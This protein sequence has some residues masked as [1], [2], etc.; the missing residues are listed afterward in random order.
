MT[1]IPARLVGVAGVA[2]AAS[3]SLAACGQIDPSAAAVVGSSSI[4]QSQLASMVTRGLADAQAAAQ[5]GSDKAQFT[6]EQLTRLI[7]ERI[8]DEAAAEHGVSVSEGDVDRQ[9]QTYAQQAGGQAQLEAQ[10]AQ[11]GVPPKDLRAFIRMLVLRNALGDRLIADLPVD[12]AKLEQAY[13]QASDQYDQ[14]HIAHILVS[15]K[16]TADRILAQAKADPGS[17]AALA[18]Q[19]SLDTQTKD[20]GGDL[21]FAGRTTMEQTSK[22]LADAVFGA[23]PGSFIEV[24]TQFGWHVVHV[25]E[26][27]TTSLAEA[28]PEL[29]RSLLKSQLDARL[30]QALQ[31][32]AHKLGIHVNPRYGQWDAATLSVVAA[33]DTVS[34]P[35]PTGAAGGGAPSGAAGGQGGSG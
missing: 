11:G 12:K 25:I 15:D 4:P 33:T 28:T 6:R 31:A 7:S 20:N 16:A 1:R 29:R 14:M 21:G 27:R 35:S 10:A 3:L 9:M 24:K 13:A 23:Q 18:K 26:Q 32:A 2:L 5:F 17:F 8:V 22:P 30:Q 19:Y 34:S